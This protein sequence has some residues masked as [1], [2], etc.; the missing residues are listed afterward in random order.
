MN[1]NKSFIPHSRPY[2]GTAEKKALAAVI[3]SGQI[4]GGYR[5]CQLEQR[6]AHTVGHTQ[7]V[8]VSSGTAAL[9]LALKALN[10]KKDEYVIIPSYVCTALLNA[11]IA[12]GAKPLICDIDGDS[13]LITTKTIKKILRKKTAVI[14]APHLF[15]N[16]LDINEINKLGV[17]VIEDCAQCVGAGISGTKVGGSSVL[18]IFSF[19]AT[20]ILGAG[21]GGMV[22]TSNTTINNKIIELREYDNRTLYTPTFNYKM[23]DLTAAVALQQVDKLGDMIK[24]RRS[25]ARLFVKSVRTDSSVF[26]PMVES[27]TIKPMY[28]RF[29]IRSKTNHV[30]K[31]IKKFERNNIACCRPVFKPL[32]EYLNKS[33][34]PNTAAWFESALSI[35]IYP[36]LSNDEIGRI[37]TILEQL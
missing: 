25:I 36:G 30:T 3:D 11:V 19:Y 17:P 4:A 32:H 9:Y 16:P 13:G 28:Y 6:L 21:E 8:A 18:S 31:I 34:F 5:V 14:I 37:C 1:T 7:G 24:M 33:G 20:K 23:S 29:I 2:I 27:T 22:A 35:P 12:A 10:V 15:G 26:V